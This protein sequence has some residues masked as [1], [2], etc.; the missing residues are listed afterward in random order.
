MITQKEAVLLR[1]VLANYWGEL[2]KG[3]KPRNDNMFF[4]LDEKLL[5]LSNYE[6]MATWKIILFIIWI[7]GAVSLVF[8]ELI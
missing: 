2:K 1:T 7:M 8:R 6:P 5:W 3:D 4:A